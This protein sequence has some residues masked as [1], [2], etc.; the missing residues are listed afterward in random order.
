VNRALKRISVAVL[1]MFL[2]LL[3]NVNYLQVFQTQSL[4]TRPFNIRAISEAN[5]YQRGDIETA[6]GVKVA[7]TKPSDDIYK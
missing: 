6:D 1:V 7:T 2:L 5:Q 4:S 3:I